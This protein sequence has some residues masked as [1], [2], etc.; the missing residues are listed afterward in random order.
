MTGYEKAIRAISRGLNII[1]GAFLMIMMFLTVANIIGR[2]IIG[3]ILGTSEIVGFALVIVV[4]FGLA[5]T[6]VM[7]GHVTVELLVARFSKRAQAI[8][9]IF[10]SLLGIGTFA[11]IAWQS[12]MYGWK[13]SLLGEYAPVLKFPI[14]PLRYIFVFGCVVLC[15]ALVMQL[16]KSIA[17]VGKSESY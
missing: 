13:Q 2:A 10:V 1:G 11:V 8:I 4:G 3:P 14:P 6:A 12:T 17:A 7:D 9:N 5:Y 16:F 15:L